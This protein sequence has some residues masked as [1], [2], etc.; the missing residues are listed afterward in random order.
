MK[1]QPKLCNGCGDALPDLLSKGKMHVPFSEE[2]CKNLKFKYNELLASTFHMVSE[3]REFI[4]HH[5]DLDFIP[6]HHMPQE[7]NLDPI[8]MKASEEAF[9]SSSNPMKTKDLGPK[10]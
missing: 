9:S 8:L 4:D 6:I 7:N 3:I 2:C 10:L 1:V 5:K